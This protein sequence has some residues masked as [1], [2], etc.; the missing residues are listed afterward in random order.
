MKRYLIH[1][2]MLTFF[3]TLI[4]GSVSIESLIQG[5]VLGM[6]ISYVFRDLFPGEFNV[7]SFKKTPYLLAYI[8][9][10]LRA[11]VV[12][13]LQVAYRILR[14]SKSVNPQ[15]IEYSTKLDNPTGVA[16]LADSITLTPGTLVLDYNK[17]EGKLTVHCLTCESAEENR[18]DIKSWENILL[19]VF[20]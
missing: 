8:G 6:P 10:F 5:F 17:N 3:W 9:V 1:G 7:S 11:L 20:E 4:V 14:P 2:V 15:I 13:N 19:K 16:V 18:G 12:S